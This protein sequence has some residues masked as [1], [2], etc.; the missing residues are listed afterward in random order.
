MI[1]IFFKN[2]N[3]RYLN[4]LISAINFIV[5]SITKSF[6]ILMW[7]SKTLVT[8]YE[9]RVQVHELRVQIHEL[10]VQIYELE[11]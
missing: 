11:E 6:I 4:I 8:S 7:K 3:Q 2:T 1:E 10:R 5:K 9:L